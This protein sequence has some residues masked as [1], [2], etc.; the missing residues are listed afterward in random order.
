M[1]WILLMMVSGQIITLDFN[2]KKS[3]ESAAGQI[4]TVY[5]IQTHIC[6]YKGDDNGNSGNTNRSEKF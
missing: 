6:I 4:K 2:D 3:C 5:G 1:S